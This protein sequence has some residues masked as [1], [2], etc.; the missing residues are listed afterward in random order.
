MSI[1][2]YSDD[3]S[4]YLEKWTH[5]FSKNSA[6][7]H[8]PFLAIWVFWKVRNTSLFEGNI[9]PITSILH[10]I[11]HYSQTYCPPVIKRKKSRAIGLGPVIAYPCGLFDGD[12]AQGA[13]GAGYVLILSEAHTFKFALGVGPCTNTKAELVGLWALLH[14]AQ[15][16]GIPTLKVYGDSSVIINWAKGTAS[17]SPPELHHWCRDTRKLCSCFLE[18]SFCHIY[19]EY[20]QH[21]DCLS[22]KALSLAPGLGNYSE[23]IEGLL[24]SHDSFELF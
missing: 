10:H 5:Y 14:I 3:L 17:L 22:K 20:N 18:L 24:A 13:G 15:M 7:Y 12:S 21:A 2:F 16:M 11:S 19:R 23:F 8:L 1:T 9:V 4:T 6:L